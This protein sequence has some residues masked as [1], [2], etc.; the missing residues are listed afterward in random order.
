VGGDVD[1]DGDDDA[2]VLLTQQAGG[3]GVFYY[4]A[5]ALN[6]RGKFNG[7]KGVYLGDRI[8]PRTVTISQAK[9]TISYLIR[10]DDQALVETST[11][12]VTKTYIL[13]DQALVE[14]AV[15]PTDS[16]VQR[17]QEA[18]GEIISYKDLIIIKNP[19]KEARV[20]SPLTVSGEARGFWYFE[21]SF[22][23]ALKNA[24]G[25]T[26]AE[27]FAQTAEEWMTAEYVPFSGRIEF[28]GQPAGS[29]GTLIFQKD[30]PSGLSENDDAVAVPV[31][32]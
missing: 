24:A 14:A 8:D 31:I 16:A 27:S 22:P 6:D 17:D 25:E 21:A 9:V 2:A 13:R 3:S 12:P 26:I 29:R 11:L 15:S 19:K 28:T 23:L 20:T 1:G 10:A 18:S 32:F 7:T 5:A 30:N 4:L